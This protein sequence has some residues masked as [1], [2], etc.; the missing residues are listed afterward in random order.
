MRGVD[1]YGNGSDCSHCSLKAELVIAFDR[2]ETLDV[3][4]DFGL[5]ESTGAEVL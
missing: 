3:A 1:G 4:S 2:L 5:V